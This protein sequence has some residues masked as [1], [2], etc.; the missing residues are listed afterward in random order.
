MTSIT[1][2][3]Q[4]GPHKNWHASSEIIA[5]AMGG[6]QFENGEP[7]EKP[8]QLGN[9]LIGYAAGTYAAVGTMAAFHNRLFTEEGNH[10]DISLQDICASWLD[11]TY[12]NYQYPPYRVTPRWG[13]QSPTWVPARLF[14]AKDGHFFMV[15]S[16]RWNLIAAWLVEEGIDIGDLIDPKYE[17]TNSRDL[18]WAQKERIN[19]L[20]N[21]LGMKY[22][23]WEIMVEGQK[24]EIPTTLV[25][26][27][28]DIYNDPQLKERTYFVEMEHPVIGKQNYPGAPYKFIE[29]PWQIGDPA[30][31][32]GQHNEEI[33]SGLGFSKKDL[34]NLKQ[35]GAI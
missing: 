7:T 35:S 12:G 18:L 11:A 4:T 14:R 23:K 5:S 3:G 32:I 16:N 21:Q 2:F 34:V 17:G 6:V 8:V 13:S 26:T 29:S 20:V 33:Y 19:D 25:S 22:T 9:F 1:P 30:P 15:G 27:T 24:R 31:L 10:V 28:K